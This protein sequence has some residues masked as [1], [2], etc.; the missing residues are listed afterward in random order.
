[1]RKTVPLTAMAVLLATS[2]AAQTPEAAA[3]D[4]V[5]MDGAALGVVT[6]SHVEHAGMAE[7]TVCHHESRPEM[8]G[9]DPYQ[10]CDECHAKKPQPPMSTSLLEAF[11]DRRAQSGVCIDCHLETENEE[12]APVRCPAC[13]VRRTG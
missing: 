9:S 8:P 7:C 11:H 10:P 2:L 13:H 3:P 5:V 4:T 12:A 1:M 6:F